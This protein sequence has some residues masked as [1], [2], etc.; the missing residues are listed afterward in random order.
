MD[1]QMREYLL[2]CWYGGTP[3]GRARVHACEFVSC[4]RKLM[5]C[6]LN[7]TLA[8]LLRQLINKA[9]QYENACDFD[10]GDGAGRSW[11]A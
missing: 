2:V 10:A 9:T 6:C 7:R 4:L 5:F 3:F 1:N 8:S 11:L